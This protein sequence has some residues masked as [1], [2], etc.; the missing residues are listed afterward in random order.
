MRMLWKVELSVLVLGM[1]MVINVSSIQQSLS[2]EELS[3]MAKAKGWILVPPQFE[4]TPSEITANFEQEIQLAE[5]RLNK[6]GK[7]SDQDISF[8]NT[9]WEL[10]DVLYQVGLFANRIALIK[11]VHPDPHM[12]STA[13]ETL[14]RL[15]DW[16]ISIEYREDIYRTIKAL[17]EKKPI[18]DTDQ[19][20]Y[21]KELI[22]DYKRIGFELP[23]DQRTRVEHLRKELARLGTDFHNNII[24]AQCPLRFSKEELEGV[25]E[26]FLEQIK[27]EEGTYTVFANITYHYLTVMETAKNESVRKRLCTARFRLALENNAPLLKQILSLRRQI[28]KELGYSN[29]ADYVIEVRMAQKAQRALHFCEELKKK[30]TRRYTRELNEM[31]QLKKDETGDSNAQ[32]YIWDWNYFARKLKQTKYELDPEKIREYFQFEKVLSGMFDIFGTLFDLQFVEV[33]NAPI[34]HKDVKV[35]ALI[36]K[37]TASPLGLLYLDMFPREGKYNH[38]AQF[39][40]VEGKQWRDGSYQRPVAALICNFTAPSENY[41]SLL[42]HE[43]VETLF[44]EFGHALHT[45]LTTARFA[46]FSGTSVPRDFVEVPSQTLEEWVWRPEAL[47]KF[48]VHYQKGTP[49]PKDLIE[50]L[51]KSRLETIGGF[52]RR[53]MAF[54]LT[55]LLLH[56]ADEAI[57]DPI[58]FANR[59]FTETFLPVP[60][61][62]GFVTY[63]GHLVGYDASYYSYAW[64]DVLVAN[65]LEVFDKAHN[66]YFDKEVARRFRR[67][68]LEVGDSRPVEVS[69]ECFLGKGWSIDSFLNRYGLTED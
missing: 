49:L 46:R 4:R 45:L 35:F 13:T 67:E 16:F 52:Y 69:L 59:C 9:V 6:I 54:A 21:L 50:R 61:D 36:D 48:A 44:H 17:A 22:R 24:Q 60:E 7:L 62:T 55:D 38:F 68:I 10:D 43:E 27:N 37:I 26:P 63:F 30:L 65:I 14:K 64:S 32:V 25:P 11:D 56:I 39:S 20:K 3:Q 41:P 8:E 47:S 12:R 19:D 1:I 28:A 29:W 34:W 58:S 53:Q 15:Q 5:A 2:L 31:K 42:K 33:S 51:E 66:G 40:L 23:L 18:L 57:A